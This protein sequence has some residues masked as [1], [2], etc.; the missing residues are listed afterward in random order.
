MSLNMLCYNPKI[1]FLDLL[2]HELFSFKSKRSPVAWLM[3]ISQGIEGWIFIFLVFLLQSKIQKL[4][5]SHKYDTRE[6]FTV[7]LQ[8]FL[9]DISLPVLQVCSRFSFTYFILLFF[10]SSVQEQ[11]SQGRIQNNKTSNNSNNNLFI[12]YKSR[13]YIMFPFPIFLQWLSTES[14]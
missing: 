7:V 1:Q 3:G 4:I 8:P 9:R 6:D 14:K 11:L 13:L 5:K 12:L 10:Y 2:D